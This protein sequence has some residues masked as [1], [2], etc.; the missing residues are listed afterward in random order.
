MDWEKAFRVVD[1]ALTITIDE[2]D[3]ALKDLRASRETNT[4]YWYEMDKTR[5]HLNDTLERLANA[6]RELLSA[7]LTSKKSSAHRE[8]I[9]LMITAAEDIE[10]RSGGATCLAFGQLA[11]YL[12]QA[13]NK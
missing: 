11:E 8:T 7:Q 5:S 12:R 2:R 13:L 3:Q 4:R 1:A 9:E 6:E 10:A